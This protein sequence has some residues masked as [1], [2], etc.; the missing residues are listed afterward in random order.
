LTYNL[1]ALK[2]FIASFPFEERFWLTGHFVKQIATWHRAMTDEELRSVGMRFCAAAGRA[3]E[4]GFDM[5]ELH[6]ANGYLLCEYLSPATNKLKSGFGGSFERRAA[7]PLAVVAE[8]RRTLPPGVPLGF[9]LLLNEWVPGGIALDE[10]IAFARLLEKAG[11]G[12]L[13]AAAGTFNSIFRP[14]VAKEMAR[15]AYLRKDMARLTAAVSVPTI[16]SGRVVT[17]A[18]ANQLLEQK[19]ADLIGLGR[20]LRADFDWIRKSTQNEPKIRTC[21]NCNS[22]LKRVVLEQGFSCRRW[23]KSD[24]LKADL[25]HL[26]L[27]RNYRALWVISDENDLLKFKTA[28]PELLPAGVW[29]EP[30][31]APAAMFLRTDTEA[32]RCDAVKADLVSWIRQMSLSGEGDVASLTV[33]ERTVTGSFHQA[34]AAEAW[35][36]DYGMI[37]VG[38]NRSQRWRERLLYSLRNKIVG[39]VNPNPRLQEVAVLLDFSATSLL[40]LAFV[41]HAYKDRP[42]FCCHFIHAVNDSPA[43]AQRRWEETRQVVGLGR[44][45]ALKLIACPGSVASALVGELANGPYGTIVMGKRGLSGIKR[46]LLG[47]VSRAVVRRFGNHS[48]FLVD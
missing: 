39:L 31:H 4:A 24:Q 16:V 13:S 25:D 32:G 2:D 20:P 38:R 45:A 27:S 42:G 17:P 47:S 44:D 8:I 48:L 34:V 35:R 30:R 9:R 36:G 19:V 15:P 21:I 11:I 33:M 10:S 22:C 40:V 5:I 41:Q 14:P 23:P 6:G 3:C 46:L 29:R 18:L 1:G 43:H 12:Y 26:L 37:L 28:L 7:F